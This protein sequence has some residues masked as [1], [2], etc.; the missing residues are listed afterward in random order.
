MENN[1]PPVGACTSSAD[2]VK[3]STTPECLDDSGF[4]PVSPK[5]P[6]TCKCKGKDALDTC[7]NKDNKNYDSKRPL[8]GTDTFGTPGVCG[9]CRKD[10]V[11]DTPGDGKTPGS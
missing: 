5:N 3:G 1:G 4:S 7:Y 8:C 6:G 11:E 2:C 10:S 9:G